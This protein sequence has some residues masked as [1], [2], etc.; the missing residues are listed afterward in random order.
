M[1]YE[2]LSAD[3]Q[4]VLHRLHDRLT[5]IEQQVRREALALIA[6]LDERVQ[7]PDDWILD[8]ELE[9]VVTFC[10][11]ADDPAYQEDDDNILATVKAD[12]KGLATPEHWGIADGRN[13]NTFPW[14]AGH[15]LRGAYHCWL[16]HTLYHRT[17]LW[18]ADLLR[19]GSLWVEMQVLYQH[20]SDVEV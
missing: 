4:Q 2:D 13:H 18:W 5:E 17:D 7:H 1:P 3:Q 15:P 10:L 8:Y 11:R 14:P 20:W 19:I 9:L 12:L 6:Q 16:Y